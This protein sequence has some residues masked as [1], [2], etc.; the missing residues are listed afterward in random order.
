M[1]NTVVPYY[2]NENGKIVYIT[3]SYVFDNE[4]IAVEKGEVSREYKLKE[5]KKYFND[6]KDSWA[7]D[8]IDFVTSREILIGVGD[9]NFAPND[10]LT[11][12]MIITVFSRL[13]NENVEGYL[14]TFEDVNDNWYTNYIA[15]GENNNITSGLNDSNL[16]Y[17]NKDLTR[18]EMAILLINY[19]NFLELELNTSKTWTFE[20]EENISEMALESVYA[21]NDLGIFIGNENNEFLPKDTLTRAEFSRIIERVI[22][23]LIESYN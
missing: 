3:L 6:T 21:L 7:K 15:W 18:E 5:N 2:Y 23:L 8:S 1:K 13:T 16:F 12:A 19:F 14:S 4:I 9:N 10:N 20:D 17:P 11:R 22:K